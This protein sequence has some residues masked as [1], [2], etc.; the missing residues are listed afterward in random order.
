MDNLKMKEQEAWVA[1]INATV[2]LSDAAMYLRIACHNVSQYKHG[3][4]HVEL[5]KSE[6]IARDAYEV[7]LANTQVKCEEYEVAAATADKEEL[8]LAMAKNPRRTV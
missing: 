6:K 7:A 1:Y 2:N 8:V 3:D 4:V 5:L